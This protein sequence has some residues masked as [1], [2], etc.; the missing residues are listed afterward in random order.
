MRIAGEFFVQDVHNAAHKAVFA[1]T[2]K[3]DDDFS[4]QVA[5]QYLAGNLLADLA[6]KDSRPFRKELE[7]IIA[8]V[9]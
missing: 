2:G 1:R 5:Q 7:R 8:E 4:G 9:F 6:L 3:V